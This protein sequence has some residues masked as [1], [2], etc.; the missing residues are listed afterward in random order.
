MF[1]FLL[2]LFTLIG[3][4]FLSASTRMASLVPTFVLLLSF[5]A[6]ASASVECA[7]RIIICD[8]LSRKR[9]HYSVDLEEPLS[10]VELFGF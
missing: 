9:P 8:S 3:T 2:V 4:E 10:A 1:L 6:M 5:L 7:T